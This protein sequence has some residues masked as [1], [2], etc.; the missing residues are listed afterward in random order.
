M[1]GKMLKIK[2]SNI[3]KM[4]LVILNYKLNSK[5]VKE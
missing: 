2:F 3:L 1:I 4:N 5:L